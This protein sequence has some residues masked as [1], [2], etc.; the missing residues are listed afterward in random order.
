M[1]IISAPV[2]ASSIS[3]LLSR[4]ASRPISGL[5][6]A[7][8]PSVRLAP[9]CILTSAFE[10]FNTCKSVLATINSTPFTPDSTI[11]LTAFPPPP[12]KPIT[13]IFAN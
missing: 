12:P 10:L 11:L 2:K 5:L 9:N 7:P 8:N 1:K 3:F 6:P 4:A 13:L